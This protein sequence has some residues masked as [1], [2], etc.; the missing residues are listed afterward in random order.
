[1]WRSG[2]A[3]DRQAAAYYDL[4]NWLKEETLDDREAL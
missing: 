2:A 1:L 4:T 3:L